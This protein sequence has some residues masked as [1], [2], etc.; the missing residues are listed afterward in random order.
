MKASTLTLGKS[1]KR[2]LGE[3]ILFKKRCHFSSYMPFKFVDWFV[4]GFFLLLN[5]QST[6]YC[7]ASSPRSCYNEV[8]Q[9]ISARL[10]CRLVASLKPSINCI[11]D[12]AKRK[13]HSE[14]LLQVYRQVFQNNILIRS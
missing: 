2:F 7:D 3:F 8:L 13:A 4:C 5:K 14:Q 6:D 11:K 10:Y 12:K 1:V 9:P